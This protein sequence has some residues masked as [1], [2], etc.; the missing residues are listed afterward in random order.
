[1]ILD[2]QL[3]KKNNAR[4]MCP[5]VAAHQ[6]TTEPFFEGTIVQDLRSPHLCANEQQLVNQSH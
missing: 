3:S 1:V 2:Q 4:F 5:M 6:T